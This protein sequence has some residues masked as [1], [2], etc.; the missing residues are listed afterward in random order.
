MVSN[1]PTG[2]DSTVWYVP[3]TTTSVPASFTWRSNS[4]AGRIQVAMEQTII[5]AV[6]STKMCGNLKFFLVSVLLCNH[7]LNFQ[8]VF[9]FSNS[10]FHEL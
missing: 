1:T 2:E 5:I 7:H 9:F 10:S 3:G 6:R 8:S 4:P